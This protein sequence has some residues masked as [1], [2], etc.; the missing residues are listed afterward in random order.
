VLEDRIHLMN[1]NGKGDRTLP[2]PQGG[3]DAERPSWSP[4]GN[5]IAFESERGI[6]V[7]GANG[8][9]LRRLFPN[10]PGSDQFTLVTPAWSPDGSE[11]AYANSQTG[12]L[13]LGAVDGS[14]SKTIGSGEGPAWSPDG[15]QLAVSSCAI[16]VLNRDGSGRRRLVNP[17]ASQCDLHPSW[18]PDGSA[19]IFARGALSTRTDLWIVNVDGT[20]LRRLTTTVA[21]KPM[22]LV[23]VRRTS[24][25]AAAKVAVSGDAVALSRSTLAV[26]HAGRI[27]LYRPASGRLLRSIPVR[28]A[29]HELSLSGNRLVFRTGRTIRLLDSATGKVSTLA[30]AAATPIGLSISGKRVAWAENFHRRGRI[31]SVRVLWRNRQSATINRRR[32]Q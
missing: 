3:F 30:R 9:G 2:G 26:L 8:T 5:R 7:I 10:P 15:K 22:N 32:D 23:K 6:Y 29:A 14:S 21:A 24:G 12:K 27:N 4:D 17:P 31:E 16:D 19:I 1:V 18:S 20:G 28:G 25:G 11:I 13:I